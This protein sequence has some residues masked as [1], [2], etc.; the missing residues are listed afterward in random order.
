MFKKDIVAEN[1]GRKAFFKGWEEWQNPYD[2]DNPN[3][4][5][6]W[7]QGWQRAS[8]EEEPEYYLNVDD[9]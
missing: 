4:E 7:S 8:R 6:S 3:K 2:D 9:E 1:E 5:W